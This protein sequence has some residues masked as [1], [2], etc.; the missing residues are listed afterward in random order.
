MRKIILALGAAGV[1]MTG[2]VSIAQAE[3]VLTGSALSSSGLYSVGSAC[4]SGCSAGYDGS[5]AVLT[6]SDGS[7]SINDTATL[8]IQNGYD[9]VSLGT[10]GSLL[11]AG[12]ANNVTFNLLS[13]T[14]NGSPQTNANYLAYWNV[15][16]TNTING[17]TALINSFSNNA[18]PP[19]TN[20]LNEP[21]ATSASSYIIDGSNGNFFTTWSNVESDSEQSLGICSTAGCSESLSDWTVSAVTISV[22]GWDSGQTE[23]DTISSVS[24]PGTATPLPATLP[25]F[26]GGLGMLGLLRRRTKQKA[27]VTA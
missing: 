8:T 18:L 10:L 1:A 2:A 23:T 17:T 16:L 13:A 22:G 27:Q 25:L 26:A 5:N 12:A 3:V 21:N 24:L 20:G 19:S 15:E 6:S 7:S 4:T 9:G 11:T 14:G